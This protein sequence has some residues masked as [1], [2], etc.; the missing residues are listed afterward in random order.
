MT[1]TNG[2]FAAEKMRVERRWRLA[3]V[4]AILFGL[5]MAAPGCSIFGK[6]EAAPA[7]TAP[8][9]DAQSSNDQ[10]L[11][12]PEAK[13]HISYSKHG[14]F[15]KSL[16]VTK[17]SSA[18][19]IA[20][21]PGGASIVRFNGGV[22]VWRFAYQHGMFS[23]L[24]IGGSTDAYAVTEIQYGVLPA[25]FVESMPDSGPPEPLEPGHYYVFAVT[26]QSGSTSYQAVKVNPDG[27]LE[28][29]D[30]DPRAGTSFSLCC[31]VSADFT[32]SEPATPA[33]LPPLP[34]GGDDAGSP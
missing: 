16:V 33:D 24:P 4:A 23:D 25:H 10:A 18:D 34:G 5:A 31:N 15:L 32:L 28:G 8:A 11:P 9:D 26:R 21:G 29:Y 27:S 22:E 20:P 1:G 14:D 30:A 17:Y 12:G 7:A 3:A 2:R 6:R 19:T 13:I